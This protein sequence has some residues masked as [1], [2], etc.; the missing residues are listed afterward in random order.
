MISADW[1]R[2]LALSL[3]LRIIRCSYFLGKITDLWYLHRNITAG[4]E[5]LGR[6]NKIGIEL[7]IK[8][9]TPYLVDP[10]MNIS[11]S[12][13]YRSIRA[14]CQNFPVTAGHATAG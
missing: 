1:I 5:I 7:R 3:E 8:F 11:G 2:Q 10:E 9:I 12:T 14:G 13:N 4:L 6:E